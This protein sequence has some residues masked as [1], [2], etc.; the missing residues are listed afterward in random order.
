MTT[1]AVPS[2]PS[3]ARP[4]SVAEFVRAALESIRSDAEF[5]SVTVPS[6]VAPLETLLD[7]RPA[8]EAILWEPAEGPAF[9]AVGAVETLVGYGVPRSEQ[10]RRA[11]DS[12]WSKIQ[13]VTTGDDGIPG[14]RCFG[15]LSFQP[16][17]ATKEPWLDFGDARFILPRL[18]YARAGERA[19]LSVVAR[20]E[21]ATSEAGRRAVSAEVDGVLSALLSAVLAGPRRAS[22]SS[23]QVIDSERNV[24]SRLP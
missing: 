12:L 2:S 19:W 17:W 16:G 21:E 11:A 20:R 22:R 24:G 14:P 8:E 5:V 4:S 9:A 23:P 7:A 15:G 6:P 1:E 18:R 10:I 3:Q 13:N